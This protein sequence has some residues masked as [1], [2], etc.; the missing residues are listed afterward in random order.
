MLFTPLMGVRG[1]RGVR[2][3]QWDMGMVTEVRFTR[4]KVAIRRW[5]K[6]GAQNSWKRSSSPTKRITI[7]FAVVELVGADAFI[8]SAR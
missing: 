2:G 6:K 4:S 7:V 5:L 8:C 3:G 1:R